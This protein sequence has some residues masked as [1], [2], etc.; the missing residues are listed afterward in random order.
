[1]P[2]GQDRHPPIDLGRL[3]VH[4][5][6]CR[7]LEHRWSEDPTNGSTVTWETLLFQGLPYLDSLSPS[8]MSLTAAPGAD[9]SQKC[10]QGHSGLSPWYSSVLGYSPK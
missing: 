5:R 2:V 4:P 8:E 7:P 10:T 9:G 1:M 3:R 6:I